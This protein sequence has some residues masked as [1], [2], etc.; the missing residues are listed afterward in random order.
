MVWAP[1][2]QDIVGPLGTEYCGS[3]L[4]HDIVGTSYCWPPWGRILWGPLGQ[5][6][7]PLGTGYCEPLGTEYYG[8]LRT[9]YCLSRIITLPL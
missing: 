5:N 6:H 9:G 8:S 1:L 4:R 2:G 3:P 7:G